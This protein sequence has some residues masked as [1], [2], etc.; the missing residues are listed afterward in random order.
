MEKIGKIA[1]QKKQFFKRNVRK[2]FKK[3]STT[4]KSKIARLD[5]S[6]LF[7]G[8][9]SFFALLIGALLLLIGSGLLIESIVLIIF[10]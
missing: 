8:L 7:F 5:K 9:L 6:A 4:P 10:Y 1:A 2:I 3:S